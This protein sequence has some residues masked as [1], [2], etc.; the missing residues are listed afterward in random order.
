[1]NE[2]PEISAW[3][4]GLTLVP[5]LILFSLFVWGGSRPEAAG[6]IPA[7]W[8]K[9]AHLAW[10]GVL[11]GLLHLGFGLRRGLWVTKSPLPLAGEDG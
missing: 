10:F 9:L 3:V 2:R 7:P 1:M 6:L 11:A 5:A 4:R 8:D